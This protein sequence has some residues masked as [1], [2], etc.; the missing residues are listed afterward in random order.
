MNSREVSYNFVLKCGN[1]TLDRKIEDM[2][3]T[4]PGTLLGSS[5]PTRHLV[6]GIFVGGVG[7][8]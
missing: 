6:K 5:G 3:G 2:L 8:V 1:F 4:L 7:V